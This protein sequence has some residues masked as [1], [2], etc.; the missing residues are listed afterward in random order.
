MSHDLENNKI[1]AAL[2]VAGIVAMLCGFVA[3]I[4]V[5]EDGTAETAI[6][7]DTTALEAAASGDGAPVGPDPILALLG[8]ADVKRGE[9][10]AKACLACHGFDK[11]GPSKIGPNLYGM[12]NAKKAHIDS[13]AYSAPL[14]EMA[15]KGE[16]WTYQS[17]NVFLWKPAAYIKGTKMSY[18]GLKKPQDRADV[19]AYMRSMADTPAPLPS[20]AEIAAEAPKEEPAPAEPPEEA[21]SH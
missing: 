10:L 16:K 19:I 4:L 9:A 14:N 15:A 18:P 1:F 7:I 8:S 2:L 5:S 17:L 21:P 20:A 13:F 11:G 12:V 6:E 3:N